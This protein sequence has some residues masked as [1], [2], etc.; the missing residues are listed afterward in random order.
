[1]WLISSTFETSHFEMQPSND[2]A[3]GNMPLMSVTLDTLHFEISPL[4]SVASTIKVML[5]TLDTSHLEI[6]D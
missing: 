3:E 5:V 1:M 2:L 6:H 4:N